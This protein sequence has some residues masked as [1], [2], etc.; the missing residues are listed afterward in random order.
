MEIDKKKKLCFQITVLSI[1]L[2]VSGAPQHAAQYP[3][4]VD[5]SRCPSKT[6]KPF[7]NL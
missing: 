6:I 1:A 3:A 5:P 2:Y 7:K 4:G